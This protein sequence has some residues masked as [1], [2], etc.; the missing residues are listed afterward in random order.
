MDWYNGYSPS[1]R[2]RKGRAR[3]KGEAPPAATRPPC[4]MC[5]DPEPTKIQAHAEDYSRPYLWEPPAPAIY[6]LCLP[7][8]KRL[9]GRFR[10]PTRWRAY[11][12]FL[13]KG[14]YGREVSPAMLGR[15]VLR[16]T[17][18]DWPELNHRVLTRSFNGWWARLTV[19]PASLRS[20]SYRPRPDLDATS[21]VVGSNDTESAVEPRR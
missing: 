14:Y 18:Y 12:E 15:Y 1:E 13:V 9:H 2:N 5:G 20:E 16:S 6:A 7:C 19:D 11:G 8:H 21:R 3:L 17:S 10:N 4:L